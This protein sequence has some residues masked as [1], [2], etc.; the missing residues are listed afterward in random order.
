MR[1]GQPRSPWPARLEMADKYRRDVEECGDDADVMMRVR[2]PG[3]EILRQTKVVGAYLLCALVWGTTWFAIRVS[4]APGGYP[5][6]EAAA[7][8]FSV[9][10]AVIAPFVLSG[11]ARLKQQLGGQLWR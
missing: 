5:T 9:A 4:I 8:R 1:S 11:L 2:K 10:V 6:Y 7:L 3:M